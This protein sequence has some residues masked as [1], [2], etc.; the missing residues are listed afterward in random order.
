MKLPHNGS[1]PVWP[2][3]KGGGGWHTL[4]EAHSLFHAE[5][6]LTCES[7]VLLSRRDK[8]AD[9]ILPLAEQPEVLTT[10]SFCLLVLE[11]NEAET[12]V[13][14]FSNTYFEKLMGI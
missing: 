2:Q 14:N 3:K 12:L 6:N 11:N 10:F 9:L 4:F 1:L 5:F 8:R 13:I 7:R